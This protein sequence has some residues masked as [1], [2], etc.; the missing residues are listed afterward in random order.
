MSEGG[1]GLI[2]G[3]LHPPDNESAGG[4]PATVTTE[5]VNVSG[6]KQ[7]NFLLRSTNGEVLT[8]VA[9]EVSYDGVTA[10]ASGA[11]DTT[12]VGTAHGV[13]LNTGGRMVS[14]H[15]TTS[16]TLYVM[17]VRLK[18]VIPA[19]KTIENFSVHSAV[20]FD[21]SG[22]QLRPGYD[23]EVKPILTITPSAGANGTVDPAVP[24]QVPHRGALAVTFTPASGYH[25][26]TLLVDG[27]DATTD[28][29]WVGGDVADEPGTYTFTE[30]VASHAIA[31][32]F[33]NT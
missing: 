29:E 27:V 21:E 20:I 22:G 2:S 8:S 28:P 17:F 31:A 16:P 5:W 6:A 9:H 3:E 7:A 32:T 14:I 19:N 33:S 1:R 12:Q 10:I 30:V 15:P 25:V 11:D 18:I 4:S 23:Y 26:D 24:T 13:A